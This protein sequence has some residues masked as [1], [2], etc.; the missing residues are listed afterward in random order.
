MDSR[1]RVDVRVLSN[2]YTRQIVKIFLLWYNR[3]FTVPPVG[4]SPSRQ[5]GYIYTMEINLE[6]RLR[7]CRAALWGLES[8]F[9]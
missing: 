6:R 1:E 3:A 2:P 8:R 7:P 9:E 4:R 5:S